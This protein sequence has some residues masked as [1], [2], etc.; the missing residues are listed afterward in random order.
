MSEV[1]KTV[2][3]EIDLVGNVNTHT[4]QFQFMIDLAKVVDAW[5]IIPRAFL[6]VYMVLLYQS[7]FWFMAL[8]DPTGEQSALIS[9]IV[10]SG[11][12]WFGLYV[13][14]KGDHD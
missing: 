3:V 10:G 12:A 6:T 13:R 14:G 2:N 9:V 7:C 11:A 4:N 1:K 5:R 8:T